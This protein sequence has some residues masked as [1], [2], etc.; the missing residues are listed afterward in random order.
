MQIP[1]ILQSPRERALALFMLW[2]AGAA[3]CV[4][5]AWNDPAVG[6]RHSAVLGSAA[7][8][9]AWMLFAW[10][11]MLLR[12]VETARV[13]WSLGWLALV[14]HL[15][16]A[17]GLGHGWSHAA[18][19]EH[20]REVGGFGAGIA[21]NY[22]FASAWA[23][24]LVQWWRSPDRHTGR[25]PIVKIALHGFLVFV[26]FN[27]TVVFG[28]KERRLHYTVAFGLLALLCLSRLVGP[29]FLTDR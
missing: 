22:L 8:A 14:L 25:S 17:F 5:V 2:L 16:F 6:L 29:S 15:G 21:V 20:V 28:P 26:V 11:A 4:R 3:A 23:A 13:A 19:V 1:T 10:A 24:D 7:T 18:A 12:L 27:A 9:V